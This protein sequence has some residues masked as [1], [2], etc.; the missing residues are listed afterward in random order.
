MCMF[1]LTCPA[2]LTF[3]HR[4]ISLLLVA[5]KHLTH[6][7]SSILHQILAVYFLRR[8]SYCSTLHAPTHLGFEYILPFTVS[9]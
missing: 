8:G 9:Y 3:F 4:V 1:C 5:H 7:E 2:L 6:M